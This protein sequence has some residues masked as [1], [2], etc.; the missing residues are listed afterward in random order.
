M[1]VV[2]STFVTGISFSGR[3]PRDFEILERYAWAFSYNANA[4]T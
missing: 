3:E 1:R 4:E 2:T